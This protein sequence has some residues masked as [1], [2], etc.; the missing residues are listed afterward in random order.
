[1]FG[2][3]LLLVLAYIVLLTAGAIPAANRLGQSEIV[4]IIA[5]LVL[6]PMLISRISDFEFS[7]T[8]VRVKLEEVATK[9]VIQQ[10]DIDKL[11]FLM[12]HFLSEWELLHLRKLEEGGPFP[13][14]VEGQ[15][16]DELRRLRSLKLIEM[17]TI[18]GMPQEG[19]LR[20][21]ARIT[22]EGKQYLA[23]WR[24]SD[25]RSARSQ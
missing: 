4:L 19:D 23:W 12:S 5:V 1:L 13:Y 8:R 24:T 14:R 2:G 9:Q 25:G 3:A 7:P 18:S 20:Q 11:K 10:A 22:E 17:Q 21:L 15:F 6:N 16:R